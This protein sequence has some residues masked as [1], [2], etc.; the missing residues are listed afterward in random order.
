MKKIKRGPQRKKLYLPSGWIMRLGT[1]TK[2]FLWVP[3]ILKDNLNTTEITG[4][5]LSQSTCRV[6]TVILCPLV[7]RY[8]HPF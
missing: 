3:D 2:K 4:E 6:I 5:F 8:Y 7:Y 1:L